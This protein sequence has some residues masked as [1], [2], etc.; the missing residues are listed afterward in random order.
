[1]SARIEQFLKDRIGL[2]AASIGPSVIGAAVRQ[3]ITAT[4]SDGAAGYWDRLSTSTTEQQALIEAVVVPETWFFRYPESF[5]LLARLALSRAATLTAG[6]KLRL[7]SLPCSTGEEPYSMAMALLDAGVPAT[8]FEI[9]ALDISAR[10]LEVAQKGVFRANS[11]R[12][13]DLTFRARYFTGGEDGFL[14]N[15]AVRAQVRFRTANLLE[16]APAADHSY[17]FIFCR[18]LLIYFDLETQL[19]AL[20]RLERLL[21]PQGILFAGPAEASLLTGNGLKPL[22][23]PR[24]FAFAAREASNEM[25]TRREPKAPPP[26]RSPLPAAPARTAFAGVK[27]AFA[28]AARPAQPKAEASDPAAAEML[29]AISRHADR[30]ERDAALAL[31]EGYLQKFGPAADIFCWL[32]LLNDAAGQVRAAEGYYRK[33]LYL[34]PQH[35]EAKAHMAALRAFHNPASG[36][37]RR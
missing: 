12:A 5:Q 18:N 8:S 31:C 33:A 19:A 17:D 37:G 1:M 23:E 14:L 26:V 6:R 22:G 32:G 29:Q 7:L 21:H 25:A 2:D 3:R 9:D 4:G 30:G 28:Q 24:T 11:F 15:S 10:V 16:A 27:P 34:E 36:G 35:A 20:A 13:D